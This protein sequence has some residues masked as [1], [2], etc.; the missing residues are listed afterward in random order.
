MAIKQLVTGGYIILAVLI[1]A[2]VFRNFMSD[3][4]VAAAYGV[5]VFLVIV[6]AGYFIV[7]FLDLD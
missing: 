4:L 3:L 2:I 6:V 1:A 7:N 5:G